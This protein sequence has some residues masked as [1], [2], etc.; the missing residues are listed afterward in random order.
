MKF[1][2]FNYERPDMDLLKGQFKSLLKEFSEAPTA[3]QQSA[4]LSEINSL[5]NRFTTLSNIV[6]VRHTIDTNDAKYLDEQNF[7]DNVRPEFEELVTEYYEVLINSK[8][9][10]ELKNAFGKQLFDFAEESI[11]SFKPEIM[12]ELKSQN[13]LCTQYNQLVAAAEIDFEG[14][15]RNLAAL[16]PYELSTDRNMRK[17]ATDA[18][19]GYF[20][21][22]EKEFD[23]NYDQLVKLR[24]QMAH[25]LNFDNY[26][27][28]GYSRMVRT[29]YD[30]AKVALF[31]DEIRRVVTPL[32][33]KLKDKQ[34]KRL[35]LDKLTYY[36]EG[37]L[38]KS[39]NAKPKGDGAW[40]V[41]NAKKMYGELSNE[42]NE[43]FTFMLSQNLMD[44][45][46]KKG[47]A[48]GGYCTM[49]P[50]Y[51]APFIFSNFN[52]TSHDIDVLTHEAGHAF[53]CY[54]SRN[55]NVAEYFFP[56][57]EACEIHSMSM[58][59]LTW[60]W[61]NLFFEEDTDKYKYAHLLKCLYFL[62]YGCTV[63]EFQHVIYENPNLTPTERKKVWLEIEN[64]YSPGK[65]YDDN[66]YLKNGGY[67]QRQQ[68]I[69]NSPF[70]YID[71][72]LAQICAF[73]FW[74]KANVDR[75]SAWTDYVNLC[76]Q[77]GSLPFLQLVKAANLKSPFDQGCVEQ[78]I[79]PIAKWIDAIDDTKF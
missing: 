23:A 36:D 4:K 12:E 59:F 43:F 50:D 75:K 20:A 76:R 2:D 49:F 37:L 19:F 1:H 58:E 67:W 27:Q 60:P 44:L 61:M 69:Y 45:E 56:T 21:S 32:V 42:T 33:Q 22:H 14:E 34:A 16:G 70:Y 72:V 15:K 55:F 63:D 40:I 5:R 71:Y 10:N 38:F 26:V 41:A 68:H 25:K 65:D 35:G 78:A 9:R 53:Q 51:K 57:Y 47:K 31:R 77:G 24:D 3:E 54:E 18:K 39:G 52:G 79:E 62:P 13:Q 73:Q 28:L 8:Y 7:I 11:K 64:K 66:E 48:S 30:A 74:H 17:K 6:E 46:N 29:E